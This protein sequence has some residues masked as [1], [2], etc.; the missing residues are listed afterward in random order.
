MIAV[1]LVNCACASALQKRGMWVDDCTASGTCATLTALKE[2]VAHKWI[3]QPM[4][5]GCIVGLRSIDDRF[6]VDKK[7]ERRSFAD[8]YRI[9]IPAG[10]HTLAFWWCL[11]NGMSAYRRTGELC[12]VSSSEDLILTFEAESG[13]TYV[14]VTEALG[15]LCR[16]HIVDQATHDS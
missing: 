10:T 4:V 1:A 16:V 11:E 12:M 9:P 2:S 8:S 14:A 13:R 3:V 15:E 5:G 6:P 7:G